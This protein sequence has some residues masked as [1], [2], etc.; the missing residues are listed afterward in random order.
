MF[1]EADKNL[2]TN[3]IVFFSAIYSTDAIETPPPVPQLSHRSASKSGTYTTSEHSITS[4]ARVKFD[5]PFGELYDLSYM[6]RTHE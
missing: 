3:H 5:V 6:G 2:C 1:H 4:I